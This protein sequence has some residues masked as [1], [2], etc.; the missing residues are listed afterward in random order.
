MDFYGL[1]CLGADPTIDDVATGKAALKRG[2]KGSAVSYVQERLG[3]TGGDIDGDFGAKTEQRVK[4]FQAAK[5]L[6]PPDGIVGKDTMAAIDAMVM[7]G[8]RFAPASPSVAVPPVAVSPVATPT[9][10]ASVLAPA[11]IKPPPASAITLPSEKETPFST[12]VA[13]GLGGLAAVGLGIAL[14]KRG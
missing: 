13:Y 2:S 12:K 5:G 9:P 3:F 14:L 11:S 4:E 7:S 1:D 6:T 8:Q 10:A